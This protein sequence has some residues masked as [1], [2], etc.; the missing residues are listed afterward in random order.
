M[1]YGCYRA[2][3]LGGVAVPPAANDAEVLGYS[4]SSKR[5]PAAQ[6]RDRLGRAVQVDPIKATLKAPGLSA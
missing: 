3:P 6:W 5:L 4:V 1:G 2:P